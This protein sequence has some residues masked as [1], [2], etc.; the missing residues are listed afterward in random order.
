METRADQ[1]AFPLTFD[2]Q[3]LANIAKD[4]KDKGQ[5]P[6]EIDGMS[7]REYACIKNGIA[8]TGDEVLDEI[9][10]KGQ[11]MKLAGK[12]ANETVKDCAQQHK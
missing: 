11:R 5:A 6:I 1:S 2:A 9:I 8:E 7:L 12:L 10:R 3:M 4:V